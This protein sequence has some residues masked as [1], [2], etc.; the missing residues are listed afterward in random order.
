MRAHPA[1]NEE[2]EDIEQARYRSPA[3]CTSRDGLPDPNCTP[4]AVIEGEGED[5]E[6][7]CSSSFKTRSA[8]DSGTSREQKQGLYRRYGIPHPRHNSGSTQVCEIDHLVPLELAGAD[9]MENLWPECSP[10]Y[11][12]W[13]GPG[14]KDKDSFENWLWNQVCVQRSM[15]LADAQQAI[16]T[17]WRRHWER[18]GSPTCRN[19]RRCE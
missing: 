2:P 5:E 17:N 12:G 3:T 6:M 13:E 1:A 7:V 16:A 14:F 18:A 8:R 4:G 10:G 11:E 15:T 19:R 9:T